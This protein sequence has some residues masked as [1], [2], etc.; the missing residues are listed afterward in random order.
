MDWIREA[1]ILRRHHVIARVGADHR[2]AALVEQRETGCLARRR[3]RYRWVHRAFLVATVQLPRTHHQNIAL[4]HPK[5]TPPLRLL[6]I[7]RHHS[8]AALYPVGTAYHGHVY[9]HATRDDAILREFDRLDGRPQTG[10]DQVCRAAIIHL[11]FPE[12]VRQA[13]HVGD[14]MAVK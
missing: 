14:G 10:G 4:L 12:E 5:T 7:L 8:L 3:A 9:Q 11:A 13:V 1:R 2:D 6:D